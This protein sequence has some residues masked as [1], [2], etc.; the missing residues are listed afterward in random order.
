M[1][2]N[3]KDKQRSGPWESNR[4]DCCNAARL[5]SAGA[6]CGKLRTSAVVRVGES[7]FLAYNDK[8]VFNDEESLQS[9][10]NI[11]FGDE[12][13]VRCGVSLDDGYRVVCNCVDVLAII[14]NRVKLVDA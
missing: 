12:S 5:R 14:L 1:V 4:I 2:A 8:P 9:P 3:V 6:Q 7:W 10:V 11:D 13:G